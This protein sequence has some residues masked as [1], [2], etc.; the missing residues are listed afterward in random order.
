MYSTLAADKIID[1][2]VRLEQRIGERFQGAGL[3]RVCAELTEIARHTHRRSTQIARPNL[4]LRGVVVILL[5]V[6]AALLAFLGAKLWT[7][8]K[9]SNDLYNTL[10]GVDSGFNILLLMGASLFFLFSI[11]E[12][13]KRR[14][15]LKA[16]HELRSIIHVI[17]MHQLTKDPSTE[18][19]INQPTPSSP[20]RSLTPHEL[21]RY[22]DYCSEML[23]LTAK[24]AVLYAQSFP[25][26]IVTE[27][28]NDLERTSANLSQKIWQKINIMERAIDRAP[29]RPPPPRFK[30]KPRARG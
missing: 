25:D 10:Q 23:S 2:L 12:R 19:S 18:T 4:W 29:T 8:T 3:A 13:V 21:V 11:E 27:A 24:V 28:V 16:L 20:R 14:R 17:D 22:L 15:A 6:G 5:G 1:T 9:T 30:F 26:P 7:N